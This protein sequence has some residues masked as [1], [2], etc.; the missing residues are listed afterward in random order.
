[1]SELHSSVGI[2]DKTLAEFVLNLARKAPTV[3]AFETELKQNEADF[4]QDLVNTIYAV[5]TRIFPRQRTQIDTKSI[6]QPKEQGAS[7]SQSS[8]ILSESEDEGNAS[9]DDAEARK[10]RQTVLIK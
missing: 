6:V 2:K 3:A 4:E 7:I 9:A 1:M 10:N 8:D 5:V